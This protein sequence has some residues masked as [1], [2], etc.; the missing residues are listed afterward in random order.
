MGIYTK[1][2][3]RRDEMKL[4][5]WRGYTRTKTARR[6]DERRNRSEFVMKKTLPWFS[7]NNQL[8]PDQIHCK[9]LVEEQRNA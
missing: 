5:K 7:F 4:S 2:E 8:F 1:Y 6:N 3:L 9:A